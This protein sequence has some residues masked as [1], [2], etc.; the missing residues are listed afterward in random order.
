[1]IPA[2]EHLGISLVP[3]FPLAGG[4]L[5]GKYEKNVPPPANSR[6]GRTGQ[7][8]RFMSEE[9]F[10]MLEHWRAFA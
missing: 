9:N 6:F 10:E 5:T 1:M 7:P 4:F 3:Y 8:S 2:C